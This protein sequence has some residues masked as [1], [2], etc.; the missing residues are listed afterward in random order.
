ML[1]SGEPG[2][3]KSRLVLALRE[4]LANDPHLPLG[5]YCS[6]LH[7]TSPLY[8]VIGMLE[9]AA[10]F[11]REDTPDER[12]AKIEA[13]LAEGTEEVAEAVPL[14]AALLALPDSDRYPALGLSPRRQ[15]ERTLEVLLQQLAGLTRRRPVLAIYED[16]HWADPT[17][18]ELLDLVVEWVQSLPALVLVTF[19]PS[20]RRAGPG[21]PT[22]RRSH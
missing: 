4:H 7:Q 17:T 6:P 9:R 20:S 21:P 10:G 8:P 1:L 19:V 5:H 13:L 18:L 11:A 16:V 14:I 22:S 15:K 12:F 3:G 2:V